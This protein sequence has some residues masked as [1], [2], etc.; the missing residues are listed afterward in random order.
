MTKKTFEDRH[1]VITG[2]AGGIAT[3]CARLFLE[4][5]ATVHLIDVNGPRLA[6]EVEHLSSRSRVSFYE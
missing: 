3:A 6:K 2:G 4:N 1:I 5:G